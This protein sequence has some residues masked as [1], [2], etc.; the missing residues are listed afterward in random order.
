VTAKECAIKA[1]IRSVLDIAP[2]VINLEK[3]IEIIRFIV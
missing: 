1:K 2:R 3:G